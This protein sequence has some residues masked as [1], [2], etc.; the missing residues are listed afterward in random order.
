MKGGKNKIE[1][2]GDFTDEKEENTPRLLKGSL[3]NNNQQV[4]FMACL[5][6]RQRRQG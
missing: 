2:Q 1:E 6:K 4:P 5:P 3:N